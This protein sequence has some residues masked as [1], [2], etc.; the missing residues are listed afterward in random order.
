MTSLL[1]EHSTR[2]RENTLCGQLAARLSAANA[3]N[4][5][6]ETARATNPPSKT[7]YEAEG[8]RVRCRSLGVFE[9]W[10]KGTNKK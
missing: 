1:L 6:R 2:K 10:N 5:L 4:N 3:D 8:D 7:L 9:H